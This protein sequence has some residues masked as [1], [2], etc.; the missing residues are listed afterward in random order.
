MSDRPSDR[1]IARAYREACAIGAETYLPSIEDRARAIDAASPAQGDGRVPG[2]YVIPDGL[3]ADTM[4]FE[5]GWNACRD[6]VI[7]RLSAAPQPP[8]AAPA[9]PAPSVKRAGRIMMSAHALCPTERSHPERMRWMAE[10]F[11][12]ELAKENASGR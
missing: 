8:P 2:A 3:P 6:F 5:L 11:M 10:Y 9:E 1:A 7:A 12:R 4:Q